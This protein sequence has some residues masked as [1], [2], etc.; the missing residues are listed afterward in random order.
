MYDVISQRRGMVCDGFFSSWCCDTMTSYSGL[1]IGRFV[2]GVLRSSLF[3]A[4]IT[5]S[6]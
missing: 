2:C 3:S 4:C 5:L 1:R 6:R